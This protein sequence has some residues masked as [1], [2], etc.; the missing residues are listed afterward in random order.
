MMHL[1][2]AL[3]SKKICFPKYILWEIARY[4]E[5]ELDH[6]PELAEYF[7]GENA[8]DKALF[9]GANVL[10]VYVNTVS[11]E[12]LEECEEEIC[13]TGIG[14]VVRRMCERLNMSLQYGLSA[15]VDTN[16]I[17]DF[18]AFVGTHKYKMS[19]GYIGYLSCERGAE[20]AHYLYDNGY[21]EN[22]KEMFIFKTPLLEK[23]CRD[24]P[25]E[26]L[27]EG[28]LTGRLEHVKYLVSIGCKDFEGGLV[29]ARKYNY[30]DICEYLGEEMK[31][32]ISGN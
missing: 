20:I 4:A 10:C 21:I 29:V 26:G 30:A 3:K 16:S 23:L 31:K 9:Y 18:K 27:S 15:I 6:T 25:N 12:T 8:F 17:E 11:I 24:F 2:F 13:T 7:Y 5:L 19:A 32:K 22:P 1:I 14:Y 28:V